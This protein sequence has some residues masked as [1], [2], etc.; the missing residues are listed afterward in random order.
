MRRRTLWIGT[1]TLLIAAIGIG[2]G[3]SGTE[4]TALAAPSASHD[5]ANSV[6]DLS[7]AFE[8][9]A[10]TI[11]PSV[12]N[13]SSVRKV[14]V[15]EGHGRLILPDSPFRE[16]FGDEF[17][18]RFF[19]PRFRQRDLLQR[20]LG[21]GVIVSED[22]YIVTNNH[23]VRGADEVVVRLADDRTFTAK[24]VGTDSQTDL[25]VL[26]I[27]ADDLK[28]AKLGDSDA[29]RVGEWVVAVGNPFQ[30]SFTITAGIVSAKGRANVGIAD[31]EDF[32]QT[33]AA[34]NPGNSGGPLVNLR[35]EVVG[36][37][38][39]IFTR[40]GG[41][42]GI[43]FAIPANMVRS[44]MKS[45]I[46]E[47]RVVRGWLGVVIQDLNEG[48]ARSF[49][50]DSTEGVLISDVLPDG[51]GDRAGL[52]PGDIITEYEG[53]EVPNMLRLRTWIAETRPGTRVTLKVFRDGKTR[54]VEVR[55]GERESEE[56]AGSES[57]G[58]PGDLGM[59]V[60][61]LTPDLARRLGYDP[62]MRGVV[63]TQIEPLSPAER[64]GL[65]AGDVIVS[66]Q[67]ERVSSVREFRR[68]L[69]KY[70]PKEGVRLGVRSG[71]MRRFV[72][73]QVR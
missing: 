23:V 10:E 40:S 54:N 60:R 8:R 16:F 35:G 48:L 45:L 41:Y 55:I 49:G 33:D 5:E 17:F 38:T 4:R 59:T 47:G 71:R 12:V 15:S 63:I 67:G 32:I 62:D 30:L 3:L 50:Y 51:P 9:V 53:R 18:E 39:A 58:S 36:I 34:I 2:L 7:V 21:S 11:R 22:G 44:V 64:A 72:F 56:V 37:N 28:P 31:Y 46:E 25:A 52:R 20:S 61:D 24:V 70:D 42:M 6:R 69:R 29:L 14:R 26:K 57:P 66:V 27:D 43:G 13:I 19:A 1:L 65:Q 73:I 68:A